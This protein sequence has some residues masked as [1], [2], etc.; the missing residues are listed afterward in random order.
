MNILTKT[1]CV[2]VNGR[3]GFCDRD[4]GD[5]ARGAGEYNALF[6]CTAVAG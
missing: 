1:Y 6:Y 2:T 3:I 5:I 4:G